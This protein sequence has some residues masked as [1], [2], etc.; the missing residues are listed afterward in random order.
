MC[1]VWVWPAQHVCILHWVLVLFA[2]INIRA[3]Q[4][5]NPRVVPSCFSVVL[6]IS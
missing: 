1:E 4:N 5:L 6:G 3:D 2:S